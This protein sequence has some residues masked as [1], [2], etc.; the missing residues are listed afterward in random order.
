MFLEEEGD[1]LYEYSTQKEQ[2]AKGTYDE[3]SSA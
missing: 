1:E 2:S 3:V